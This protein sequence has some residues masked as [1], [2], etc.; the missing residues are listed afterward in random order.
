MKPVHSGR[1]ARKS[2]AAE[3]NKGNAGALHLTPGQANAE[4]VLRR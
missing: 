3:T 2:S 4:K 1:C